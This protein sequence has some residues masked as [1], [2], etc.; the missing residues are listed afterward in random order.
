LATTMQRLALHGDL[1]HDNIMQSTRGWL[2]IDP[3]GVWGDPAYETANVF[4]NPE[5]AGDL[6]YQ[7]ARIA[8]LAAAF[9][10][11]L[12]HDPGR[13]LGW[14]VAHCALSTFWSRAAGLPIADDMALLPRLITA[15]SAI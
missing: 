4:R 6:P 1:H 8:R 11:R 7:P 9:H 10:A 14:A 3:K 2:A 13:M 5:G 12:G 15:R